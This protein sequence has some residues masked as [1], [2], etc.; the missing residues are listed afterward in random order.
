MHLH[1]TSARGPGECRLAVAGL[2]DVLLRE[3]GAAGLRAGVVAS[4]PGPEGLLSAVVSLDGDGD[5]AFAASWCGTVLWTCPSP[6]RPG[7]K[8]KNWFVGVSRVEVPV[9]GEPGF[10]ERDLRWETFRSSG[11]GGQHVNTT[12]SA[13]RLRHLPSGIVVECREERSQHR[14]RAGAL[15]KLALA[16]RERSHAEAGRA[17]REV[18]A[19]NVEV[20]DRGGDAVRAYRGPRFDRVR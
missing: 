12:D 4:E 20:A 8:R 17:G 13:V 11:A 3:A 2:V 19:R 18:W 7:W 15:A 9:P 6:L 14:N 5:S 16:L 10:G 1:L